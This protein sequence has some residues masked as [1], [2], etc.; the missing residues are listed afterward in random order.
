MTGTALPLDAQGAPSARS[1]R[2]RFSLTW[3]G[4]LPFAIFAT[5]FLLIPTTYLIVSKDSGITGPKD[6]VGKLIATP[7]IAAVVPSAG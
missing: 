3:L 7:S 2:R 4:L 1:G 5:F 6:L